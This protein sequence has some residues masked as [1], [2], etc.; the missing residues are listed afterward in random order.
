MSTAKRLLKLVD[1]HR[2]IEVAQVESAGRNSWD[3]RV[4]GRAH[5]YSGVGGTWLDSD[6]SE[7]EDVAIAFGFGNPLLPIMFSRGSRPLATFVGPSSVLFPPVVTANWRCEHGDPE[8][9]NSTTSTTFDP[10]TA[11]TLT[12][13]ADMGG[14]A[15]GSLARNGDG[16]TAW[17]SPDY[18]VVTPEDEDYDP[19]L[20][21]GDDY[22]LGPWLFQIVPEYPDFV[23]AHNLGDSIGYEV[24]DWS[25]WAAN[26]L[27]ILDD[28]EI[29]LGWQEAAD[30]NHYLTIWRNDGTG[31]RKAI[32]LSGSVSLAVKL[33]DGADTIQVGD[34]LCTPVENPLTGEQYA[35]FLRISTS[36]E[37][38]TVVALDSAETRGL[39]GAVWG[40]PESTLPESWRGADRFI[41]QDGS[42]GTYGI[43][44]S[45][46]AI[47]WTY[48]GN[49]RIRPLAS[50]GNILICAAEMATYKT[51]TDTFASTDYNDASTTTETREVLDDGKSTT[52]GILYL[53]CTT[54]GQ[55]G[56]YPFAGETSYSTTLGPINE[57]RTTHEGPSWTSE[58]HPDPMLDAW[59][60]YWPAILVFMRAALYID[61]DPGNAPGESET[62]PYADSPLGDAAYEA[63]SAFTSLPPDDDSAYYHAVVAKMLAY[64]ETL[65]RQVFEVFA[66]RPSPAHYIK[67]EGWQYTWSSIST[68]DN[69]Y[70]D[71]HSYVNGPVEG[72]PPVGTGGPDANV[73][74]TPEDYEGTDEAGSIADGE[75]PVGGWV[76]GP[77]VKTF[78]WDA[79]KVWSNVQEEV[80]ISRTPTPLHGFGPIS[81][82]HGMIIHSPPA[83][84]P[85][86]AS[87][88]W[89]ARKLSNPAAEE[90]IHVVESDG[91]AMQTGNTWTDAARVFTTYTQGV[92]WPLIGLDPATGE[93]V[94]DDPEILLPSGRTVPDGERLDDYYT[95]WA[96]G[97][98]P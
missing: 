5:P 90:W 58:A 19:E 59:P 43:D 24:A 11:T 95:E 28:G 88:Y 72:D 45:V 15:S 47:D 86:L 67:W 65:V 14:V 73:I 54:G 40:T 41:V 94:D 36:T 27:C 84:P 50:H 75:E 20:G 70:D 85:S 51:V 60:S 87:A 74:T 21:G 78:N 2:Q 48:T 93:P 83:N 80:S 96:L 30:A 32:S 3:L 38:A 71:L 49:K 44:P 1:K 53:S 97:P 18:R 89:V 64:R 8:R 16:H 56:Y 31:W 33:R 22:Q 12:S 4:Q 92:D 37:T 61:S 25:T 35:H 57:V 81:V 39:V 69:I 6:N 98:T 23:Y 52:G 9:R 77:A 10:T 29:V 63:I 79:V 76:T 42:G 34:Y 62:Y 82:A 17:V 55:T 68:A 13:L 46:P 7:G 91:G 26:S 66:A